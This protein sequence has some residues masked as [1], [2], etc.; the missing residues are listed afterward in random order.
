MLISASAKTSGPPLVTVGT[1]SIPSM[2]VQTWT[3]VQFVIAGAWWLI[4]TA[5]TTRMAAGRTANKK[6]TLNPASAKTS[7]PP[8]QTVGTVPRPSLVVHMRTARHQVRDTIPGA[9]WWMRNAP[10]TTAQK[11]AAGRY[12]LELRAHHRQRSLLT[13]HQKYQVPLQVKHQV[14][15]PQISHL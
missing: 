4:R 12:A 8:L 3:A 1:V 6:H 13:F 7:G 10:T 5:P 14:E 15:S 2:V 9:T 11:V